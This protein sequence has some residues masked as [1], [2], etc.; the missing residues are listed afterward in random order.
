MKDF[1]PELIKRVLGDPKDP[2]TL[3]ADRYG[4]KVLYSQ[5]PDPS[6]AVEMDD[7]K[8]DKPKLCLVK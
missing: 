1:P 2:R 6:Q 8:K 5:L 7:T 3:R 4:W